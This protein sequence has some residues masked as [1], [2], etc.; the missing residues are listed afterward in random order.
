MATRFEQFRNDDNYIF[1]KNLLKNTFYF[2]RG[3]HYLT[4]R[5]DIKA[6]TKCSNN[7]FALNN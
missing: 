4:T 6:Q 2:I 1:G 7:K 3:I 5:G